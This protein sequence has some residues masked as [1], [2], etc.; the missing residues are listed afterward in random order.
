MII[1]T[2]LKN[3]LGSIIKGILKTVIY[4]E[5]LYK[6]HKD[7][8]YIIIIALLIL[9]GFI[10]IRNQKKEV[11]II[12]SNLPKYDSILK[13]I[14]DRNGKLYTE[15][16]TL[17]VENRMFLAMV[18]SLA[19]ALKVKPKVIQGEDR[20]IYE[21]DTVF[22]VKPYPVLVA[23]DTAYKVTKQ[24]DYIN[25]SAIAGPTVGSIS[26]QSVDTLIRIETSK[27]NIWGKTT[28][29]VLIRNTNPYNKLQSGFSYS[30][31]QKKTFLTIGPSVN[32][33]PFRNQF[34]AGLSVQYPLIQFK[35]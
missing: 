16:S 15:I 35:R 19:K 7:V 5:N 32:Y 2:K 10:F 30:K 22:N 11:V 29:N 34:S 12:D 26:I 17:R 4:I 3:L 1:L 20:Y 21:I 33:D 24:D 6:N 8:F 18:D 9:F 27:T 14:E 25:V 31:I 23:K 28:D 13:V